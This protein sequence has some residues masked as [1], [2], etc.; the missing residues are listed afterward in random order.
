[1]GTLLEGTKVVLGPLT[2]DDA[3][4]FTFWMNDLAT[5][6]SLGATQ[7]V[8]T[9]T[10]EREFL[11]N[12]A[13]NGYHF[14]IRRKDTMKLIGSCSF[15]NIHWQRQC[16]EIGILIGDKSERYQGYGT[17]AVQLLVEYGFRVLGLR[18]IMLSVY[19]FNKSALRCYE[20][21]GFKKIGRRRN[22]IFLDGKYYDEILMDI[23]PEEMTS[24]FLEDTIHHLLKP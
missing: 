22:V 1:M 3:P 10:A 19:D 7:Q 4:I 11:Q 8:W 9:E 18:N 5:T 13:K 20:K 6:I 2:P 15:K 24:Y 21:A 12:M 14:G 23:L 17:E 16:A